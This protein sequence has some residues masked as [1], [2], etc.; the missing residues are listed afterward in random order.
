MDEELE[1]TEKHM[2][3]GEMARLLAI[4]AEEDKTKLEAF[5]MPMD[6]LGVSVP[7]FGA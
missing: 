3:P 6:V 2:S 7:T 4:R 1:C 5:R